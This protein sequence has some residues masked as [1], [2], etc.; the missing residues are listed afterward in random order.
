MDGRMVFGVRGV[1]L[2]A[3]RHVNLTASGASKKSR[4]RYSGRHCRGIVFGA[5]G[6]QICRARVFSRPEVSP[7]ETAHL[8]TSVVNQLNCCA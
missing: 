3:M 7:C 1:M 8:P 5:A 6:S 2:L 4:M